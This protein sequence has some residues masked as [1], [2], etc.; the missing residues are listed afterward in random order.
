VAGTWAAW[1]PPE[2][3]NQPPAPSEDAQEV[4][5]FS[6]DQDDEGKTLRLTS[7]WMRAANTPPEWQPLPGQPPWPDIKGYQMLPGA[8]GDQAVYNLSAAKVPADLT[9]AWARRG[10]LAPTGWRG[11]ERRATPRSEHRASEL[12]SSRGNARC[13]SRVKKTSG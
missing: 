11:A 7:S 6:L 5:T 9:L 10:L 12:Q 1:Q 13:P 4:W 8:D 3:S 2:S